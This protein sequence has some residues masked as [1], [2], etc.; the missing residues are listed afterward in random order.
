MGTEIE[1]H[2]VRTGRRDGKSAR[3][4]IRSPRVDD[5]NYG[6][7]GNIDVKGL[8]IRI[9]DRPT[10]LAGHGDFCLHGAAVDTDD[11]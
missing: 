2:P 8:G 4:A 7:I 3:N 11:R 10:G 9:I 1:V 5:H 6:G